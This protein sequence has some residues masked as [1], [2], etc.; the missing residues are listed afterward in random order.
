MKKSVLIAMTGLSI[1]CAGC[2]GGQ[3]ANTSAKQTEADTVP[4]DFKYEVDAFADL[5][6]LRYYV[7][8]FK[9]LPL[10]QKELVYYLSMAAL[11]GRD[12]LFDQNNRYNLA[13]RRTLEG[14]YTN[15]K[16]DKSI[17][18]YKELEVYLKRVWFSNGIHHHYGEE[19]FLPAFSKEFFAEQVKALPADLVPVKEGQSVED[20][21]KMITPVIFDAK[22]MAKKVNQSGGDLIM[23]SANN[24]YGEG[25]TQKE[26]QDFYNAMKDTTDLTPISYGLNS[27]LVKENGKLTE[28][29]WKVGG[30]YSPAIEKIVFWLEKAE[31]VAEN[32]QQKDVISKL[33]SYYKTG[34]LKTFDQYAVAW[35]ED[36]NSQVDFVNGFTEVY[37]DPLG[38]KAS[39]EATVNFK[40]VEA[41]KRAE[42]IS[43]NAQ[44]FE[45]HSPVD[46]RFKKETVKGVSAKVITVAQLGGDCYPATPI[47]INLPNADWIRR[48]HGSKSVTIENIMEAYDAAGAHTGF[49]KEFMWSNVEEEMIKKYG[50]IT[51]VLHTDLHECLGHGSGK[52]LPEVDPNALGEF[53]STIEEARADL[54]GLYFLA[55]NKLVELGIIP[56]AD[57]YKAEYYKFMMNGLMTQLVRIEPGKDIEEAHMRNR[58]LIAKW[59]YEKGKAENVVEYKVR[60]GKTYVVVND[61]DKLRTLFGDLLAEIQ[62]IKSEG[63]FKAAKDI[64]ANYAVKVDQKLHKEVLD[65]YKTLIMKPYKGFVNPVFELVQDNDGKIT[66]VKISYTEGYTEQM[67][68]YSKD[69]STLPTYND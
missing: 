33:I 16:G 24:Y 54:F 59:V 35:V 69:Y 46:K 6:I 62:R 43:T 15:Y 68:R 14:I 4:A 21:I 47:G 55:D 50:F 39:W 40:N 17:S 36:L 63:D 26:V 37:G 22:V 52:L 10:E 45:D 25:V 44:W 27:R 66:D 1:M 29:V 60:D 58:Q 7:P 8:G 3:K 5:E 42:I 12:I 2:G 49:G 65:R 11:E 56:T 18:D 34:D 20:F 53:S 64:V 19:K 31:E 38:I 48:D 30:L 41:T 67:L 23:T 32:S 57:A 51:D 13:I 61:Y 9:N 28:K